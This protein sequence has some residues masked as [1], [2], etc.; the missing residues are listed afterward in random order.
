MAKQKQ[1][2]ITAQHIDRLDSKENPLV[3]QFTESAWN[4]IPMVDYMT[5]EGRIKRAKGGWIAIGEKTGAKAPEPLKA[6]EPKVEAPAPKPIAPRPTPQA[7]EIGDK[8]I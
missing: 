8:V 5:N 2:L 4:D 3:K 1:K 6:K 7:G